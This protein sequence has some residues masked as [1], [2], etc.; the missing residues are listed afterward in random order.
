MNF[1]IINFFDSLD[2]ITNRFWDFIAFRT[3][4]RYNVLKI[5]SLTPNYYDKDT[6]LLHS[7][8]QIVVDYVEIELSYNCECKNKFRK[9]FNSFPF[10]IRPE[11]R[12]Q[13][14]SIKYIN[15]YI[16]EF[17]NTDDG[18]SK[19][20][21]KAYSEILSVYLWWKNDYPKRK[22]PEETYQY[23]KFLLTSSQYSKTYFAKKHKRLIDLM[24][25]LELKYKDEESKMMNKII[26]YR[27]YLWT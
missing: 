22:S 14:C 10:I 26:E 9:I 11:S 3:T 4:K 8:M 15:K 5:K 23:G 27:D 1:G 13:K 20:W 25:E 12:C 18:C 24:Q 19:R 17:G 21:C 2:V 7:M 6:I 16:E